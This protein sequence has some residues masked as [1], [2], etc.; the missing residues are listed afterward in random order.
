MSWLGCSRVVSSALHPILLKELVREQADGIVLL[1]GREEI[2]Y[3]WIALLQFFL[4]VE[5]LVGQVRTF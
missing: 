2:I 3:F 5:K 1:F 4:G